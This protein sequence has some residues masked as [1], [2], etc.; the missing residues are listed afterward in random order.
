MNS[1]F[2]RII[3]YLEVMTCLFIFFN[4][5]HFLLELHVTQMAVH[6]ELSENLILNKIT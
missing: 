6:D 4:T 1:N 2:I 5:G 3:V